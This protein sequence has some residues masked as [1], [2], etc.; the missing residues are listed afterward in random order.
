M[1]CI[2]LPACTSETTQMFAD[3]VF[4]EKTSLFNFVLLLNGLLGMQCTS[5][6]LIFTG[7]KQDRGITLAFAKS[8]SE[9]H[10]GEEI[11]VNVNS[12]HVQ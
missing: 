12:R 1:K 8:T 9:K 6:G 11:S 7:W 2:K 4:I 5:T 10:R 3:L